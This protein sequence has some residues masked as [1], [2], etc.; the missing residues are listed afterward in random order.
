MNNPLTMNSSISEIEA[1]A[2]EIANQFGIP[3]NLFDSL[4]TQESSWNPQAGSVTGAYGLT[5][6]EPQTAESVGV[7]ASIY[8]SPDNQLYGGAAYLSGLYQQYGSWSKAL[9]AYF[10]GSAA[11]NDPSLSDGNITAGE[12]ANEVLARAGMGSQG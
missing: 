8:T 2:K 4:I 7:G 1:R 3:T 11:V 10:G 9:R 6:L 5:Q 12:Y